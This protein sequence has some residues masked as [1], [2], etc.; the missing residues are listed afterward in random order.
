VGHVPRDPLVGERGETR[1]ARFDLDGWFPLPS[2]AVPMFSNIDFET[3]GPGEQ[4]C[5]CILH[6]SSL[7]RLGYG[8]WVWVSSGARWATC[9]V[10]FRNG[11][12]VGYAS[13]TRV[14]PPS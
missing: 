10:F 8:F 2:A 5:R 14:G 1:R 13:V 9:P 12:V 11:L 4:S 7:G 6:V 3:E